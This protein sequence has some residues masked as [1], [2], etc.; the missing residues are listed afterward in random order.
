MSKDVCNVSGCKNVS[1]ASKNLSKSQ[2]PRSALSTSANTR[3]SGVSADM[4][5]WREMTRFSC[6]LALSPGKY[7]KIVPCSNAQV[8]SGA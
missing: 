2:E 4:C 1:L 3:F 8:R 5:D 7:L 6:I